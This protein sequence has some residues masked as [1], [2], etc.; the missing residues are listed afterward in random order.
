MTQED[1]EA[2][3]FEDFQEIAEETQQSARPDRIS[4]QQASPLGKLILAFQNTPMQYNR[5]MKRAAQD[6]INNRGSKI[7]NLSKIAYYGAIQNAIF[8]SLQQA[9]FALAFGDD[10]EDEKSSEKKNEGYARV[11]NGMLDTLLRGSGIAGAVVST[12]KNMILEF[13]EQEEKGYRADHAYTLLEMLNLSPPVGIKAR[14]LY[15]ATQTWEFNRDVISK[16]S[17][18]N[19]DNPM[20]DAAFSAIE[21]TT[22]IPLSR[23]YSK[24][25]NVREALNS[26]NE[27]WQRV[28][29]FL[30]WS[31]WNFGIQNQDVIAAKQEVKEIKAEK[32]KEK[33]EKRKIEKQKENEA[34]VK[35][36]LEKQKKEGDKATCAAIGTD[37][38]RCKRKPV[39]GGFCTIHEKVDQR[40]D[41]KKIRCKKIKSDG[42]RCKVETS[43]KSGFCYYHD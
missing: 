25:N 9:L 23:A 21:A 19:I 18:T 34:I 26:D 8:Y 29:M 40:K 37:G 16:M 27:A 42:T 38:A 3:A 5:L 12:A 2:K 35:E 36:N 1:A 41:G 28:A 24:M 20:Y 10:D 31:S 39:K 30:G 7:E 22:N 4:M 43:N 17:K 11:T 13:L 6:L 14:K 32:S 15:S 33:A